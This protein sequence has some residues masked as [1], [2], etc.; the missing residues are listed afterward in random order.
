MT[1]LARPAWGAQAVAI[2][3][4]A[5]ILLA[6]TRVRESPKGEEEATMGLELEV[7]GDPIV[8]STGASFAVPVRMRNVG[9]ASEALMFT[10]SCSFR[11]AIATLDGRELARPD[12]LCLSVI[13]EPTLEPGE[14]LEDTIR[15]TLGEPGVVSLPPGEY[16]VTPSLL[17]ISSHSVRVKPARL[18]VRAGAPEAPSAGTAP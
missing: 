5:S 2:A 8:A 12:A 13:R 7:V 17:A 4:S 1:H 15:Y 10:N 14:V 9:R 11:I 3:L 6:C 16:R 18:E